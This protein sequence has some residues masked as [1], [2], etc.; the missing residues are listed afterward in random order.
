[1]ISLLVVPAAATADDSVF[2]F[3]RLAN[4]RADSMR[5]IGVQV[6]C[7]APAGCKLELILET[8]GATS[9][10]LGRV[11]TTLIGGTRE[12]NY[13]LLSKREVAM[14]K[15][16]PT[17]PA[18]FTANVSTAG[19]PVQTHVKPVVLRAPKKKRR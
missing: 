8:T 14:L 7:N 17:T 11:Y 15:R 2:A 13:V 6:F 4:S 1:M 5:R 3:G 18:L 19:G 9:A 12:I 10:E 16:R